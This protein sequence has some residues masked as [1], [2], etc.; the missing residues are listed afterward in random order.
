MWHG[1]PIH[2]DE[3]S[4]APPPGVDTDDDLARVRRILEESK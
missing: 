4:E 3:V 1:V 2:V